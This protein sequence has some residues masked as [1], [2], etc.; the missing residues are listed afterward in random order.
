MSKIFEALQRSVLETSGNSVT[1]VSSI[2]AELLREPVCSSNLEQCES[3]TPVLR[4]GAR[5]IAIKDPGAIAAEKFRVLSV[6][7]RHLRQRRELTKV[8]VTS[9]LPEEGK[10]VV[11]L[12]L[13]STLAR[14]SQARVLLV[15]GDIRKPTI[16]TELGLPILKGLTEWLRSDLHISEV[17][18][19][20]TP[21][22]FWFLPAGE[23]LSNP[24]EL[25]QSGRLATLLDK[26]RDTF[27]WIIIDSTPVLPV[28]DTSVWARHSD[29]ILLVVREGKS[30]RRQLRKALESIDNSALIGIVL[31][32]TANGE[33]NSYYAYY[34][35]VY[36]QE[37][38]TPKPSETY[39]DR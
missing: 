10:S 3:L 6:R 34:T 14:F 20:V 24:L 7:L 36:D 22:G 17:I 33:H 19:R 18:H 2:A 38:A 25:M 13:A 35:G 39:L 26:L 21:P 23:P 29:G 11:S 12:N 32:S 37:R 16:R 30:E 5:A 8:L 15:E 28:A 31:N 9:A 4:D 27:D 1:D